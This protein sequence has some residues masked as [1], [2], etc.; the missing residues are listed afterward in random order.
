MKNKM[1]PL[2][3]IILTILL[4][5][6]NLLSQ[7]G[8]SYSLGSAFNMLTMFNNCTNPVAVDKN[9][10][11]VIFLHRHNSTVFG[12]N[13]GN[14]R[15]D[16]STNG[17]V[18][19]NNN[20]GVLNPISTNMARYPNAVIYN[21][22]SNTNTNNAFIGY[23]A[24]TT[25]TNTNT[26]VGMVT[27]VRQLNG[28]GN[29][30]AYNQPGAIGYFIPKSLV[31]GAPGVFWAVDYSS[32]NNSI[33]GNILVY[34]GT[35]N[36]SS[37]NIIW[38]LNAT[39]SNAVNTTNSGDVTIGFDP[40]GN[41]GWIG[42]MTDLNNNGYN[43]PTFFSSTNGGSSWAGPVTVNLNSFSCITG[44]I[45]GGNAASNPECDLTVDVNGVPH[46]ILV[47]GK[48]N[49]SAYSINPSVWHHVFDLSIE[50]GIWNP[51]DLG[52]CLSGYGSFTGSQSTTGGFWNSLQAART[53][54]GTKVFFSWVDN[55]GYTL[56]SG[57]NTPNLFSIAYDV[58]TKM[59]TPLK[60]FSSCNGA[61][62]GK[63]YF[64]HLAEEVLEPASNVYKIAP[65]YGEFTSLYDVDV[66]SNFRFLD[67]CLFSASEFSIA[68]TPLSLGIQPSPTALMCPNTPLN[69]QITGTYNNILWS[70]G[71]LTNF[72]SVNTP[73]IYTVAA[74]SGCSVGTAS[75]SVSSMSFMAFTQ[76]PSI[77]AGNT[78]GLLATGNALGYTWTPGA[79]NGTSA[80][81][82][83]SVNTVYTLTTAGSG[84][85]STS[86]LN[87]TVNP[88]PNVTIISNFSTVCA[89][90][91]VIL[92]ASGATVY[93]W[94]TGAVTY[95]I[96]VTPT[97][98]TIYTLTAANSFGCV[99]TF[100]YSQNV[101]PA[102][103]VSIISSNPNVCPGGSVT[104]QASGAFAYLWNTGSNASAITV[105][106][107]NSTTYS[108]VGTNTLGCSQT[109]SYFQF[110]NPCTGITNGGS[111]KNG[112]RVFPN[113]SS[114][115]VIASFE[116]EGTKLI[117]IFNEMGQCIETRSSELMS[118]EFDV[119][120][121]AKGIYYVKISSK[122]ASGSFKMVAQ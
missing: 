18:L 111:I 39:F 49:S 55:I 56:G 48:Q 34:K 60:D 12:G 63:V 100:T 91:A 99:N 42:Y 79:I 73:G 41:I 68:T 110:V 97:A 2:C 62:N 87:I 101:I 45:S 23:M 71:G 67:N 61:V 15:Y 84:C 106:L 96:A 98:N 37:N 116:F 115:I 103:N 25:N 57:N 31:K 14:L 59:L 53:L 54:D 102:P 28:A 13:S 50:N 94:N 117:Q 70:N 85:N 7:C 109:F 19:W 78:V 65:V 114:K 26:W 43:S 4:S 77:C 27:G 112:M 21:P 40:T 46:M 17:G 82:S 29:T 119:S 105:T 86:T 89:G 88:S 121:F 92:Q 80:V 22:A 9:L 30:E 38:S 64:S 11:T 75:T 35:W 122:T 107:S 33:T 32:S 74:R 113:P 118:E 24:A 95:S 66:T 76:S 16:I 44:N 108:V 36:N 52:N 6:Q 69:L 5:V 3:T 20:N 93:S 104:L 90:N 8:V 1:K 83:P 51:R 120:R 58:Q 81:V 47:G 72:N 10:N